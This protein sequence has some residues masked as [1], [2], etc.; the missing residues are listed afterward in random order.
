MV[1]LLAVSCS[2]FSFGGSE[3]K[4]SGTFSRILRLLG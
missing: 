3:E 2:T 4:V 1:R